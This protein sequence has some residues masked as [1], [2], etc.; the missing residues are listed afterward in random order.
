MSGAADP[1]LGDG[2]QSETALRIARGTGRLLSG[3][4][5]GLVREVVLASGRRCDLLALGPDGTLLIVEIKSSPEDL[6]ADRKWPEYRPF[7]D[8]LYFACPLDMDAGLFPADAGLI[9][10][11]AHGA[12]ILREA[13]EHRLAPATRR[14]VTLRFALAAAHRLHAL[15]DPGVPAPDA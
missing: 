6:R 8:R 12:D 5:Y 1:R 4:G 3:L 14:A 2:R 10:A 9:V 15:F 7:C 13:P 11:D